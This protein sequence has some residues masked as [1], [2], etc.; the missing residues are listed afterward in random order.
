MRTSIIRKICNEIKFKLNENTPTM[1][2][3]LNDAF[4]NALGENE[5]NIIHN[6]EKFWE[7]RAF[8]NG[9][10]GKVKVQLLN[11]DKKC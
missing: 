4:Y 8:L 1:V 6:F 7:A 2:L 5:K 11:N 10:K 9:Y 3:D